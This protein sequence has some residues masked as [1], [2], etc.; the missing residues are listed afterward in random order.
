MIR[1]LPGRYGVATA[2][3]MLAVF[4]FG[5]FLVGVFSVRRTDQG[6]MLI[7]A[8][9]S[10]VVY[11]V[12]PE[13]MV[14]L[15]LFLAFAALPAGLHVGKVLGPAVVNAYQVALVLAI[16]Y[17]IPTVRPRPSDFLWPGLFGLT[18]AFFTAAGFAAGH[19]SWV[20]IR[21]AQ[22]LLEMI[23]GYLLALLIVR[24]DYVK[25]S[26]RT[27]VVILWFSAGMAV[28]SSLH[29]IELFGRAESLPE[30]GAGQALRIILF[31]QSPATGVLVALVAATIIGRV[32]PARYIALGPP[33]LVITLLS[34][35][36]NPL[37]AIVVAAAVALLTSFSWSVLRR[38]ATITVAGAVVIAM[39]V[40]G[41][42]FLLQ[43]WSTG[44]WLADQFTAF[45]HRVLSG[46]ST[47]A[48]AVDTSTLERLREIANLKRAIAQ[49]PVFGHGLGYAYQPPSGDDVFGTKFSS[50][51]SHN[52][53]LWWLVKA[54]AVGAA[55]FVLFALTPLIRALRRASAPAK[56]SAAVSAGL[57]AIS[58]VWPLPEMPVDALALGLALGS[59]MGFAGQARAA[60]DV[61]ETGANRTPAP[62]GTAG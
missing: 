20:V 7:I 8:L 31:T 18:V 38:T 61:S 9:F 14:W 15:A 36:R 58:A 17:L 22:T 54:G 47:G 1:Y 34:F 2:A 59:T 21:E 4:L 35:S 28:V 50:T 51:Y 6:A 56:I 41:S 16:C 62:A 46:V 55:V 23:A 33:A 11:R 44:A 52:F 45:S 27:M 12:K 19:S 13:A 25:N 37:I 40:S 10:L 42:L 3:A 39:A 43:G 30:T 29:A 49:A 57:L 53:Y 24:G 60:H 32:R 5:C 26:M 48:L